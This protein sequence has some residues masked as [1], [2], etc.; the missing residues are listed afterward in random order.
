MTKPPLRVACAQKQN[1]KKKKERKSPTDRWWNQSCCC[2]R[3]ISTVGPMLC[4]INVLYNRDHQTILRTPVPLCTSLRSTQRR[5]L[6]IQINA[7]VHW[8]GGRKRKPQFYI[9]NVSVWL[10]TDIT[11]SSLDWRI[12]KKKEIRQRGWRN[13]AVSMLS[14]KETLWTGGADLSQQS[15]C[16]TQKPPLCLWTQSC[17]CKSAA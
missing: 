5:E 16:L 2:Y 11:V 7:N 3:P 10:V 14:E 4:N 12:C 1:K 8:G 6:I 9:L 15:S 13:A 17:I